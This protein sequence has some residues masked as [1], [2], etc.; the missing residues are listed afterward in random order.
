[1]KKPE[2]PTSVWA[3]YSTAQSLGYVDPDE[4]RIKAE[5]ERRRTQGL[6]G[7]WEVVVPPPPPLPEDDPNTE[8]G[9]TKP[10][11]S[12]DLITRKREAEAPLEDDDDGRKYKL[13]KKMLTAG[14]D[15]LWDPGEIKLKPR[16]DQDGSS[17]T[18]DN[19][20]KVLFDTP[21]T[22]SGN[23]EANQTSRIENMEKS[24]WQPMGW[25][26]VAVSEPKVPTELKED[27][28]PTRVDPVIK[29]ETDTPQSSHS[30]HLSKQSDS[31]QTQRD[32]I[33][34]KVEIKEED[35]TAPELSGSL[36][37]KRKFPARGGRR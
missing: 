29:E 16:L 12:G 3:N 8:L 27:S 10:T 5:E 37:R 9:E 14:F 31:S 15:E 18:L 2:K 7:E 23:S 1:M 35:K 36:F 26:R 20:D 6:I 34:V 30:T 22:P 32:S 19:K 24:K 28:E 33:S 17:D 13:R 4:E 11:I 21:A 25:K